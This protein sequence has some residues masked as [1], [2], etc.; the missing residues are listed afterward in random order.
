MTSPSDYALTIAF[1]TDDLKRF[2]A[3]RQQR[4]DRKT[5]HRCNRKRGVSPLLATGAQ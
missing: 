2:L 5:A 3:A 1:S 4:G